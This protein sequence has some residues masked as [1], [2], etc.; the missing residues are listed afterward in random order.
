MVKTYVRVF[1]VSLKLYR[2]CRVAAEARAGGKRTGH[3]DLASCCCRMR[4]GWMINGEAE[5]QLIYFLVLPFLCT[6][7]LYAG[8]S[9]LAVKHLAQGGFESC[10]GRLAVLPVGLVEIVVS[11]G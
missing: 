11:A 9:T 1:A 6:S 2:H 4:R 5:G 7:P 8:Y 3:G 10:K